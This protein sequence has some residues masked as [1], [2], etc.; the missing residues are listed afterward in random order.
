MR[1][2]ECERQGEKSALTN[3]SRLVCCIFTLQRTLLLCSESHFWL[4]T[5]TCCLSCT[6]L[7]TTHTRAQQAGST[8]LLMG[9]SSCYVWM[10]CV[11]EIF[12]Q[13]QL[14]CSLMC[15]FWRKSLLSA[16]V[17][18]DKSYPVV[19]CLLGV[20]VC[21]SYRHEFDIWICYSKCVCS[22]EEGSY[23]CVYVLCECAAWSIGSVY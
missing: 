15:L 19:K 21:D 4:Q 17:C 10:A 14:S 2:G 12:F 11:D 18:A 7:Y 16:C 1:D 13:F 20:Y 6:A 3:K 8:A 5:H 22:L 23:V 9:K